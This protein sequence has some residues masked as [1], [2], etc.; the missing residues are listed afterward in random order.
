MKTVRIKD[1]K[2]LKIKKKKRK[3]KKKENCISYCHLEQ[4]IN[5]WDKHKPNKKIG[6]KGALGSK[7]FESS[8]KFL[9]I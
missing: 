7:E 2:I 6:R 9:E 5:S 3:E 4:Q 8:Y 1:F